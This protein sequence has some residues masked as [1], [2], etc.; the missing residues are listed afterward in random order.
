[1]I[2]RGAIF[3]RKDAIG[4]GSCAAA[5]PYGAPYV[6]KVTGKSRKCDGCFDLVDEGKQPYCVAACPMRCL[7]FDD[8]EVLRQK[9][10]TVSS[11]PPI[12][13]DDSTKPNVVF[14]VSRWNTAGKTDGV[15]F[16]FD[17]EIVSETI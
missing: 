11:V 14:G 6:S 4:C 8:I 17:S 12:T 16:S 15:M 10:G 9:Y 3:V 7:E 13:A 2:R 5:C 1:M